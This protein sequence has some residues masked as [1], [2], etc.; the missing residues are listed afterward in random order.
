MR[1]WL[2]PPP[3]FGEQLPLQIQAL[4]RLLQSGQL[5]AVVLGLLAGDGHEGGQFVCSFLAPPLDFSQEVGQGDR[6]ARLLAEQ[7]FDSSGFRS[8][9]SFSV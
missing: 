8:V 5:L 9:V 3:Q 1:P 4:D 7:S 2:Q 6:G